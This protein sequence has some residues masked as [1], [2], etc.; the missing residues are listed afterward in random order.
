M[1]SPPPSVPSA[2]G[3][4]A[5]FGNFTGTIGLS[6]FLG[7]FIVGVCPW[8]SRR[9]PPLHLRRASPG[10]P[11][12]RARC[13]R[14]CAGS[15]TARDPAASRDIDAAGGAFRFSLWRRHPGGT[16]FRGS[17]PGPHVPLS[18]L[19]RSPCGKRRMTQG[20]CGSLILQ[21]MTLSFTTSRRFIPAHRE[22]KELWGSGRRV[23]DFNLG[24]ICCQQPW[25]P[26]FE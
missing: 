8:T 6:D 19:R 22:H 26:T 24:V 4:P 14:T 15:Q 2:A 12:S 21:R 18:T 9:V 13:F 1:A 25:M 20:R 17:I 5:L 3:C 23:L 11:G 7:S 10:P 16:T